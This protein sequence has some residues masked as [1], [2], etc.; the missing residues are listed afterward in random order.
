MASYDFVQDAA[1][2]L[3]VQDG[4]DD[5]L[6][7]LDWA[8]HALGQSVL[9]LGQGERA[10]TGGGDYDLL[11]VS[12]TLLRGV[13]LENGTITELLAWADVDLAG[14]VY[15]VSC[16]DADTYLVSV[17]SLLSVQDQML[18]L[19]RVPA[20]E[21]PE[22]TVVTLAAP[23]SQDQI[24]WGAT[25]TDTLDSLLVDAISQFNQLSPDYRVEVVTYPSSEELNLMLLTGDAPDLID[26]NYTAWLDDTPSK[27]LYARH[28][29]LADLEPFLDQD[30]DLSLDD[31]IPSIMD[32]AADRTGGLYAMPLSFYFVTA[33]AEKQYVG[34]RTSWTTSDLLDIAPTLPEDLEIWNYNTAQGALDTFL[35]SDIDRYVNEV[36]GTCDFENQDFYDLLTLCRDYFPA[37]IGENYDPEEALIQG[38]G[39]AGSLSEFMSEAM[40]DPDWVHLGY[41]GTGGSVTVI[42]YEEMSI[43]AL[44]SQQEGAWQFLRSVL[45]YDFQSSKFGFQPVRQDAFQDLLD[46]YVSCAD[47]TQDQAQTIRDLVYSATNLRHY[48][49]VA[50][51]IVLE[52]AAAF[53]SG[54]KSAQE[55]AKIIQNRMEIYLGEQE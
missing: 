44:G 19:S 18:T 7:T 3:Y 53:F 20:D 37:E 33:V 10:V 5:T 48:D 30:P 1:G 2:R 4:F 29:Y 50:I 14:S 49:S 38:Y 35:E 36:E 39:T 22:K 43:C 45:G 11:L 9:T 13:S 28:G 32:L 26:W 41:P 15:Q 40:S 52:E 23:L 55:T 46:W 51:P 27:A 31:F 16:L 47:L 8:N 42:F 25:W 12:D 24:D 34:D 6:Y 21:I 54:D 17:T